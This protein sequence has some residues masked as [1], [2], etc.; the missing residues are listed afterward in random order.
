MS[1]RSLAATTAALAVVALSALSAC[2]STAPPPGG[3]AGGG[4]VQVRASD[5]A[6]EVSVTQAPAGNVSFSVQN[7]GTKVT[8]FYLLGTGDRILGEVENIGPGLTRQLIVEVPQGGQY[9]TACKPGMVGDGIRGPFTV[10]GNVPGS[11]E[12]DALLAGAVSGYKRYTT[13]QVEALVTRTQEFVDAVK[14][15]DVEGAKQLFPVARTYWERIEPVAESFGDLDPRIDGRDDGEPGVEF[16]GYHR[17]ERDLWVTGLQPD[18]NAMADRLMA[19]IRELQA[20][21]AGIELT[22]LQLANGAKELLDEVA[23]GKITGEE[24]RYSHTDLWDFRANVDGSQ[25]A[26]AALRP[27]LDQRDPALGPVLD[28]RFRDVDVLLEGYRQGDGF[29]LY[30]ALTE[31]DKQRMTQAIDALG[32]PVSQ[33]AAV[34]SA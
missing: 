15:G 34:I 10:T 16:T 28:Q 6:C 33:V 23:T 11:A 19:D 12:G 8:E 4:P 14:R 21:T 13:S 26:V 7:T 22:P 3:A 32:E 31:Q 20:R 18:S 5:T 30:T 24:D 25:A 29:V 1:R 27:V 17:L 9:T 2:T